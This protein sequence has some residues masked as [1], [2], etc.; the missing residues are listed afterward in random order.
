VSAQLSFQ[1]ALGALLVALLCPAAA[2]ALLV[3]VGLG[4]LAV[5]VLQLVTRVMAAVVLALGYLL[6][7]YPAKQALRPLAAPAGMAPELLAAV[8]GQQHLPTLVQG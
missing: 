4:A 8:R 6:L 7:A 1:A 2:A 3:R 5:L